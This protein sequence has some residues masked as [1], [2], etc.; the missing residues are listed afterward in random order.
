M[1]FSIFIIVSIARKMVVLEI[2]GVLSLERFGIF[3]ALESDYSCILI[4]S[5]GSWTQ[6]I[7]VKS[8]I[9]CPHHVLIVLL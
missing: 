4:S 2:I 9:L 3:A 8:S 7:Q 6:A 5:G 1:I